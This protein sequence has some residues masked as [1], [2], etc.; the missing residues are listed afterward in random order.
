MKEKVREFLRNWQV[1]FLWM[2]VIF[3]LSSI[4]GSDIPKVQIPHADKVFHFFE[5]F[6][7]G[8]LMVRSFFYSQSGIGLIKPSVF[9]AGLVF[10]LA[11]SDEWHQTFIPG[12]FCEW[13]DITVDL[14]AAAI[15]IGAF[16]IVKARRKK[17]P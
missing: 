1:T 10:L 9:S 13:G 14:I 2:L 6:V 15:G 5:Y 16:I 12:R 11:F 17:V 7:L 8:L 4:P 3:F